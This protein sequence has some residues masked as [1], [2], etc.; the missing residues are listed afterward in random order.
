MHNDFLLPHQLDKTQRMGV[1][2]SSGQNNVWP[3]IAFLGKHAL[4]D[5]AKPLSQIVILE[6]F[7]SGLR[8]RGFLSRMGQM[9]M[10]SLKEGFEQEYRSGVPG[11]GPLDIGSI[12]NFKQLLFGITDGRACKP[13]GRLLLVQWL[14]GSW[15][16]F[17]ERCQ[18]QDVLDQ[19]L[20][21]PPENGEANPRRGPSPAEGPSV[22]ERYRQV[23]LGYK[24]SYPNPSRLEFLKISYRAFRWLRQNDQAWLDQQ[25]PLP[26]RH[27][28][29]YELFG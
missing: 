12:S 26:P 15:S 13:F 11:I 25:L 28:G 17:K 5:T 24:A 23:C 29:Q 3:S 27:G 21:R 1:C 9:R 14:F 2:V 19:G 16:A 8:V 22:I 18:W 10:S 7:V 20:R 6:A 4:A